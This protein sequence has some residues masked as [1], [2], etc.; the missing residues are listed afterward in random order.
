VIG[1]HAVSA[2]VVTQF[3]GKAQSIRSGIQQEFTDTFARVDVLLTPSGAP[4]V[5]IGTSLRLTTV[6]H[7]TAPSVAPLIDDAATMASDV[8]YAHDVMTVPAS[9]AGVPAISVPA[10]HDESTG[11]P[12]T[13]HDNTPATGLDVCAFPG[14]P[15]GLQLIAPRG[16]EGVCSSFHFIIPLCHISQHRATPS[17]ELLQCAS[18]L[19][20][21]MRTEWRK[22]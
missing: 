5:D 17:G 20:R 16:H 18:E 3:H 22:V 7:I 12:L 15:L 8:A 4:S 14:L 13:S 9:L 10:G 21:S 19:E 6:W 11:A 2:Q 1:R